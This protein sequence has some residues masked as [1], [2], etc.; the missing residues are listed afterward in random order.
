VKTLLFLI[1]TAL[2]PLGFSYIKE[3]NKK[4]RKGVALYDI[5]SE[6]S[7]GIYT[8]KLRNAYNPLDEAY[9]IT[10][11]LNELAHSSKPDPQINNMPVLSLYIDPRDLTSLD[12]GI[13]ENGEKK[14]RLWERAAFV[15]LIDSGK[16]IYS[17]YVGVRV[18]GGSSR[19]KKVKL[20]SFRIYARK[21]YQS[22][23]FPKELNLNLGNHGSIRRLVVRRDT[24]L[25][26]ANELSFYL[27]NKLGGIAP[28]SKQVSF[29]LNGEFQ[30]FHLLHEH[31]SEEQLVHYVGHKDFMIAKLKGDKKIDA[32]LQYVDLRAKME[33]SPDMNFDY[34]SKL[35]DMDSVMSSLLVIMYT[36]MS[37]WAQGVYVKDLKSQK[38]WRLVSWDFD[39]AF[40]PVK[41][42]SY[43]G[44]ITNSY[45][46]KS[47]ALAM[48]IKKGTIRW[49]IFNRLLRGDKRFKEYFSVLVDK[50]FDEII[51]SHEFQNLLSGLKKRSGIGDKT[52]QMR[53]DL[54]HIK[55]FM[56]HRKRVFCDD[57]LRLVKL[58]PTTCKSDL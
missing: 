5:E 41:G 4:F 54:K 19:S 57:L 25:H 38:S 58:N 17:D 12:R 16:E 27:I 32:R 51:P 26:F 3:N 13:L 14:G 52:F 43:E 50:L 35:V 9:K 33:H 1:I 48:D 7:S 39:R 56:N 53:T 31:L 21:K 22:D 30:G 11:K 34:A 49:S 10:D 28:K 45:E 37:D 23:P 18:H 8:G 29:Y 40:F 24:H 55:D 42:E 2:L 36:G 46:I 6:V 44:A 15:K 20:K 47:V